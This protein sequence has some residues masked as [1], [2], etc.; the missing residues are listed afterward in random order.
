MNELIQVIKVLESDEV[1]KLNRYIDT[2]KFK[3]STVFG[4][5]KTENPRS[6]PDVR[7]SSGTCLLE[8]HEL[9]LNFHN[10]INQ[11]LDEYKRRVQNIHHNFS[12][13]PVPGG[14]DTY[15]WREGI[16]VLQYEKNQ[17][18][19]FHHDVADHKERKEFYRTISVIVYLTDDFKGGG[20]L[21]P[22]NSFKPK[23]GYALI[24]PS[25]WCYPH[26]GEPVTEGIKRVAVT[27][28]YVE[29]N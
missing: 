6:N 20:T 1:E 10:K 23:S 24:F 4:H 8:T 22:H 3:E 11:G 9:T 21:F 5:G 7:T 28:Y 17:E 27:W 12:H 2:L 15:S 14:Y 29:L 16:Q 25:N 18:Y 26:A 13:Y 19:K